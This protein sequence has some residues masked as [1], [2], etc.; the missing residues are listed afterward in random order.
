MFFIKKYNCQKYN[1]RQNQ[2]F[3]SIFF[4]ITSLIY[5]VK[6]NLIIIFSIKI[7]VIT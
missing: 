2:I 7:E 1:F 4:T 5:P 6:I 3:Y